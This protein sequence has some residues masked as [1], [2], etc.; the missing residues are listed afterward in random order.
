MTEKGQ[1]KGNGNGNGNGGGGRG[2]GEGTE[3]RNRLRQKVSLFVSATIQLRGWE[4]GMAEKESDRE[5]TRGGW[6]CGHGVSNSGR[7]AVY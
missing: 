1:N 6:M 4:R 2:R 3:P 5:M 7:T